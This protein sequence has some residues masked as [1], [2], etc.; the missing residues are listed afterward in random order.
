MY[1]L[2]LFIFLN[3]IR[4]WN[5]KNGNLFINK[6]VYENKKKILSNRF[7]KKSKYID[8]CISLNSI[9]IKI[10]SLES[11]KFQSCVR[12]VKNFCK[13]LF[14]SSAHCQV[15]TVSSMCM[16]CKSLSLSLKK[17]FIVL[18]VAPSSSFMMQHFLND[19]IYDFYCYSDSIAFSSHCSTNVIFS[20]CIF[21]ALA[22][23]DKLELIQSVQKFPALQMR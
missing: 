18:C 14:M 21:L 23:N 20:Y 22:S 6:D 8:I 3:A 1:K 10:L 9:K 11:Y 19:L 12:L 2:T 17:L 5:H 15:S 13:V 16:F 7:R 4:K